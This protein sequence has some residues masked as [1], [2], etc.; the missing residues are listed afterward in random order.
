[1]TLRSDYRFDEKWKF[2]AAVMLMGN[3]WA[4]DFD[5]VAVQLDPAF[6]FQ[7]GA[8]YKIQ[9]DL[10][11]FVEIHNLFNNKYQLYYNYPSLGF[12]L[13]AGIKYRF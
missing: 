6:D 11:A 13:F 7:I 8:D 10:A 5:N 2:N 12:E 1:M 9:E 3:R 4:K